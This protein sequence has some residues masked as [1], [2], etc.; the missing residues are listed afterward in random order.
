[1][2][3]KPGRSRSAARTTGA[4]RQ[5]TARQ[6]FSSSAVPWILTASYGGRS[7][8]LVIDF[9]SLACTAH[10]PWSS[11]SPGPTQ[12]WYCSGFPPWCSN[13]ASAPGA[14]LSECS[15]GAGNNSPQNAEAER[16]PFLPHVGHRWN[17]S[18]HGHKPEDPHQRVHTPLSPE[19]THSSAW[20]NGAGR[21]SSTT[22]LRCIALTTSSGLSLSTQ[23][24]PRG[25]RG[26]SSFS[27]HLPWHPLD[28]KEDSSA[29]YL[30]D[31][32]AQALSFP[33][34]RGPV[35][36]VGPFVF[37]TNPKQHTEVTHRDAW[38]DQ[39]YR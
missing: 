30:T 35:R 16:V 17:T 5:R 26:A 15:S 10:S 25:V 8:L 19:L 39:D 32:P 37:I 21:N 14:P 29:C 33:S 12:P 2:D 24:C 9:G 11:K 34:G 1:M 22:S 3:S 23:G 6:L 28:P 27:L 31:L 20:L 36:G 18:V 7:S 13:S 4:S 38:R